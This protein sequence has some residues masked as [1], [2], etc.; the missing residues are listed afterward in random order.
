MHSQYEVVLT[1]L[2]MAVIVYLTRASG[3]FIGLQVRHI[4]RLRPLLEAL[5]GCAIMAILVPAVRQ[6]DVVEFIALMVVIALMWIT[7]SVVLATGAGIGILLL[8][9]A[10]I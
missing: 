6:G 4:G 10:L 3:Y 2:M 7:D 9:P 1:I 8:G 5:P